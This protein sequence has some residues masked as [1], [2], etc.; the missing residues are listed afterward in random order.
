MRHVSEIYGVGMDEY[1]WNIGTVVVGSKVSAQFREVGK[2]GCG[3]IDHFFEA[4]AVNHLWVG[5]QEPGDI[6][7]FDRV[8][9]ASGKPKSVFL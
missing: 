6:Y 2:V 9:L 1:T 5:T 4:G 7:G 8:E 3:I